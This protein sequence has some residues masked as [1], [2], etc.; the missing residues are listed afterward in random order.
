LTNP[1]DVMRCAPFSV[2]LVV[3]L[4]AAGCSSSGS[5]IYP[6]EGVVVYA[7]DGSP[8]TGLKGCTVEFE[9]IGATPDGKKATASGEIDAE[10]KF[11]LTT[12]R[13][14]DGAVAGRHKVLIATPS[15][16]GHTQPK[17]PIGK[18]Y[19]SF[20]TSGLEATVKPEPNTITLKIDRPKK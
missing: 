7:D 20:E 9:A 8:A 17:A 19:E 14:N 10:G 2:L 12:R 11:R 18:K 15:S 6:V 5:G 3:L 13:A 4:T 16:G 1:E